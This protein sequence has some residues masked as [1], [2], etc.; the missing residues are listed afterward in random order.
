MK[1][2]LLAAG[3]GERLRPWT[4]HT[5]KPLLEV[6]GRPLIEWQIERLATAG[7]RDIVVN[8]GHLGEH[9]AARL[10]DGRRFGVAIAYSREPPGALDTGGG[11]HRALPLLGDRPFLVVNADVWIEFDYTRVALLDGDLAH[12]VLVPNPAHHTGGD[13]CLTGAR[14]RNEGFPRYTFAGIG[15]YS[16]QLFS[17]LPAGRYPLA[18]LLRSA[19]AQDRVGGQ[20][21][22]G[23]WIDVGTPQRLSEAQ[24]RAASL[25]GSEKIG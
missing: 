7:I 17:E 20:L 13:F 14:V 10:E 24:L 25:T 22:T 23:I 11:I 19:A 2:M 8:L 5:P 18:P 6:G 4:D 3:R 15:V 21:Y 1:A 12:L 16:P 9:I